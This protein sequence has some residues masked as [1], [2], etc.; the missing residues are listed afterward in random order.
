MIPITDLKFVE[1][2]F[3]ERNEEIDL[4]TRH[5]L[6]YDFKVH[7]K[8]YLL[9]EPGSGK[10]TLLRMFEK[11]ITSRGMSFAYYS[12]NEFKYKYKDYAFQK[13]NSEE[14]EVVVIDDFCTL[15]ECEVYRINERIYNR[16]FGTFVL[17]G[18]PRNE[19]CIDK[20]SAVVNLR[21]I[22]I[23]SALIERLKIVNDPKLRKNAQELIHRHRDLLCSMDGSADEVF[24]ISRLVLDF[25]ES[26]SN[27][28]YKKHEFYF[29][30][31]SNPK[32]N[33]YI[34][35]SLALLL[36]V[37]STINTSLSED[38]IMVANEQ[39]KEEI[40]T[41]IVGQ[42]NEP[43]SLHFSS[44][45]LNLRTRPVDEG[46][47]VTYILPVNSTLRVLESKDGW[48]KVNYNNYLENSL[49]EGWVHNKYIKR[50]E[51]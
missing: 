2:S 32:S 36:Y 34:G 9:G 30:G 14:S 41:S 29:H 13:L 42:E 4:L 46:G 35:Y 1:S 50:I 38:R 39:A 26:Q 28:L 25:E 47:R 40:V 3:V 19:F 45:N 6:N 15:S 8:V 5:I 22:D 37:A 48:S 31:I 16:G 23:S 10:T 21:K 18:A 43:E 27:N 24:R 44:T 7:P 51:K 20:Q 12:A 17:S 11:I 49:L 33:D